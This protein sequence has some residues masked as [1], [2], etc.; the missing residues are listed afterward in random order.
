MVFKN[1]FNK[2]TTPHLKECKGCINALSM[3]GYTVQTEFV[4]TEMTIIKRMLII[5]HVNFSKVLGYP[6]KV[7]VRKSHAVGYPYAI[8]IC[9][10]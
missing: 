8:Q 9:C 1:A 4:Y 3:A 2:R 5:R 10:A 6:V 7:F